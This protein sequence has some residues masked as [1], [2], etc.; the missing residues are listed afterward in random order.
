MRLWPDSMMIVELAEY[1][2]MKSRDTF[3]HLKR[4]QVE[5][6]QRRTIQ[7]EAMISDLLRTAAD[8]DREIRAEEERTGLNDPGHFAYPTYAKATR[9]R[10][11]KLGQSAD[12]LKLQL[13]DAKA[14]LQDA[15]EDMKK[16][17]LRQARQQRREPA[18]HNAGERDQIGSLGSIRP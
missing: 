18:E 6:Q 9:Q 3:C 2:L 14:T 4:F 15:I 12:E 5:E 17:E 10:R 11:E 1:T 13:D 8:L 16:A 7:L